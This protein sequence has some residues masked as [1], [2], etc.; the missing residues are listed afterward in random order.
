MSFNSVSFLIFLPVVLLLYWVLPQR[1]RWIMLLLASYLFYMSWN[2]WLIFLIL[3]TTAI[4]YL[5]GLLMEKYKDSVRIRKTLLILTLICCLGTLFFFKY[6]TFVVNLVI[7]SLN[8]FKLNISQFTFSL[9]LPVGISFYTFQTLSYVIDVYRGRISAERHLGYYALFV[10]YFPQLVAG[11]IE[12]PDNL[13][14]QLKQEHK[15]NS[16]DFCM[17][18][19]IAAVGFFK[20]VVIAD[21]VAVFV[22]AVYNNVAE[23]NGVTAILAT[24]LF[25]IQIYC[26]FSGYTDIAIG[27]ARMMGIVLKDNF[28]QPYLAVSIK[29]FWRRWHISLTTWF[30]DYVYIPLG[31]NRCKLWRWALNVMIVFL[32][33]GLWHG[34]A[35]TF[36]IW[37]AIHGVYQ[38]VG[39]LK[40]IGLNKLKEKKGF[41]IPD[42][43]LVVIFIRRTIT[44][45]LV[46]FAWIF[47]RGNSLADCGTI[48]AK[49]FTDWTHTGTALKTMGITVQAVLE[50]ILLGG[51]LALLH[52][53]IHYDSSKESLLGGAA[54]SRKVLYAYLILAVAVAWIA[55]T[56]SGGQSVFI[57]FQ[58]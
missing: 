48:I 49:I 29:D 7:D 11:P 25:A 55:L 46:C 50:F 51:I 31:G 36:V 35:L 16:D 45:A 14:P 8:L 43:N 24:V 4:S 20:K 38:I 27:V 6:F 10:V 53:V 26:D 19:R 28:N 34:A 30:T 17:G 21:G 23:A 5:S 18:L 1:F 33:S 9:L 22:N 57:Y 47:F 42:D 40:G 2:V 41:V 39:R 32:L 15:F 37:G 3:F 58:F 13:I 12:R 54:A 52:K 56:V 44:F